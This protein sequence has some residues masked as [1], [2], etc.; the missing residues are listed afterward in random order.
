[1]GEDPGPGTDQPHHW[2][3]IY[4]TRGATEV[5]WF[6]PSATTSIGLIERLAIPTTAA[7][8]DIGGGASLL[9]DALIEKG[10]V[11]LSVI[12]ISQAAL[13]AVRHRLG[14]NPAVSLVRAD[15]RGWRPERRFDLWHDRAVFHFLVEEGNRRFYFESLQAAIPRD[16]FVIMATFAEDGPG[17]CSGLPV[18]RYS[19]T[20]LVAML[21]PEFNVLEEFREDHVTPGGVLQPFTWLAAQWTGGP[22]IHEGGDARH[23]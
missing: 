6:Q 4:Q 8:V 10:F 21:G 18:A 16:G 20:D 2:D 1:M 12:D 22:T 9:V 7:V 13:E 14:A 23:R 17:F 19:S 11:D 5:S 3:A 15:L